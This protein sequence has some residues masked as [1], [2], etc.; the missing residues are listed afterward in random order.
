M[1]TETPKLLPNY[2]AYALMLLGLLPLILLE[3]DPTK[4]HGDFFLKV[5]EYFGF[6][7]L[8]ELTLF[9]FVFARSI[10]RFDDFSKGHK[11]PMTFLNLFFGFSLVVLVISWMGYFNGGLF[12][13]EWLNK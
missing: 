8:F 11:I 4:A 5:K 13:L 6:L 9:G 2:P 12:I 1:T 3:I 10:S 7:L